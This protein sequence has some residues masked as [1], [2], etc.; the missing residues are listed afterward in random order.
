MLTSEKGA[1]KI[2]NLMKARAEAT[3]KRDDTE[4]G[5]MI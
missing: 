2:S 5:D 1:T 3:V 4:V